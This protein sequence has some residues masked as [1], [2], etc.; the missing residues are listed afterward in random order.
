MLRTLPQ[1]GT[2]ARILE[3]SYRLELGPVAETNGCSILL[4][5]LGIGFSSVAAEGDV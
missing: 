5:N 2:E 4:G 3:C 1:R